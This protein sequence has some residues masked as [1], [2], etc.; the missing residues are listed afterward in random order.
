MQRIVWI[1]RHANR[2]DFEDPH[3]HESAERPFDTPLSPGGVAQARELGARLKR[4]SIAHIFASPFLRTVE[5]AYHVAEALDLPIRI[6]AGFSE[7][8]N[9]EWFPAVPKILPLSVLAERF[10]RVDVH[11]TSR[12]SALYPETG[13]TALDRSGRAARIIT[14]EFTGDILIV[15]HGASVLGAT[16]GLVGTWAEVQTACCCL[17]K[18]VGQDGQDG[19]W[20]MELNGDTSYLSETEQVIRLH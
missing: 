5:T 9:P 3:W 17:V 8:L 20:V 4:E 7:W 14:Q 6:E 2:L 19:G 13:E 12:V 16:R 11:Y 10:C 1:A 18:L 15:G